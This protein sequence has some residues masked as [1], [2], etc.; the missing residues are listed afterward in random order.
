MFTTLANFCFRKYIFVFCYNL[1]I[2]YQCYQV[3]STYLLITF[4][5]YFVFL[6]T[7]Q[8]FAS[9]M[10]LIS[11]SLAMS[12]GVL[13][14]HH[15]GPDFRPVPP[16]M[17]KHILGDLASVLMIRNFPKTDKK[18]NHI[19]EKLAQDFQLWEHQELLSIVQNRMDK[20]D[21]TP[22]RTR[23][24][25]F[26]PCNGIS[27]ANEISTEHQSSCTNQDHGSTSSIS[28]PV[29]KQNDLLKQLLKEVKKLTGHVDTE[30]AEQKL[31]NEWKRVAIVLDRLFM[32]VFVIGTVAT[33]L[34]MFCQLWITDSLYFQ[35]IRQKSVSKHP[36]AFMFPLRAV[37]S[38]A[39]FLEMLTQKLGNYK[40]Y[41]KTKTGKVTRCNPSVLL[42]RVR[43][44][45]TLIEISFEWLFFISK[46]NLKR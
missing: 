37:S 38:K 15:I 46:L 18:T 13:N 43:Y 26:H 39:L 28:T 9:T 30:N 33:Y 14:M 20:E 42:K 11:L 19:G 27:M 24:R 31:R 5:H 6:P 17:K 8:Y 2:S 35:S 4:Y 21:N 29:L 44:E 23:H 10:V 40:A 16:W 34:I 7:G 3:S 25:P 1:C 32:I 45:P 12:V 41:S 36:R 22:P